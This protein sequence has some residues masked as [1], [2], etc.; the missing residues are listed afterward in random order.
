MVIKNI[1]KIISFLFYLI[2]IVYGTYQLLSEHSYKVSDLGMDDIGRETFCQLINKDLNEWDDV[3]L[4]CDGFHNEIIVLEI[5]NLKPI[6][7]GKVNP[8]EIKRHMFLNYKHALEDID[9]LVLRGDELYNTLDKPTPI[10]EIY[11]KLKK[12][13][14]K[15]IGDFYA[16]CGFEKFI[17]KNSE[18]N[19]IYLKLLFS[20]KKYGDNPIIEELE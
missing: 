20:T 12:L 5:K 6:L 4:F 7:F 15:T 9:G 19:E 14:I 16:A 11:R 10:K 1:K 13:G 2:I 3:E 18:T 8:D 17:I